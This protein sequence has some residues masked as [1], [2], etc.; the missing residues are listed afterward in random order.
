MHNTDDCQGFD[1]MVGA[2]KTSGGT[3]RADDLALLME[4][5]NQ[6]NFVSVVR[7]IASRDIFSFEWHNHFWV[8]MFQFNPDDL[9][10]K[11]EVRRVVHELSAVLDSWTLALWFTEPNDWLKGQRPVD[12]VDGHFQDVLHAARAD[13]YVAAG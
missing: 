5:T 8:P 1:A 13:R 9:T 10:P 11:H 3:V 2:Y 7:R 4:H 6:G 12:R